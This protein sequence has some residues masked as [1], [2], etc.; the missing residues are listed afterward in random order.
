MRKILGF[1]FV[2]LLLSACQ[3]SDKIKVGVSAPLTG[4]IA[5]YGKEMMRGIEL[6]ANETGHPLEL[7]VEDDQCD[8]K[9]G[10]TV[11]QKL[12]ELDQVDAILGPVCTIAILSSAPYIEE[13]KVPE[14]TAGMVV[15]KVANA[16]DYHFSFLPEMK[17]QMQAISNYAKD[18]NEL[19]IAVLAINDDLGRESIQELKKSLSEQ[20]IQ[21]VAEEYL[22]K[23]ESDFKTSLLKLLDQKPDAVYL[24]GYPV[25]FV[26]I[27]RQASELNWKVSFLTWNLFQDPSVVKGLGSLAEQVVYTYPE[28][29]RDLPVKVAFKKKFKKVYGSEPTLYAANAYDSYKILAAAIQQCGKD[30]ECIKNK[31]YAIKN[32]EGA[33]GFLSV[34]ERGVG[35]RSEVSLK[36]VKNGTFVAMN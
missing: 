11:A 21:V 24:M 36:T 14:I 8:A 26:S 12:V 27:I 10:V 31:L 23:S 7:I 18:H 30:K 15:Q 35:Q 34:D 13:K 16:G 6:A 33:N 28:D 9:V 29:P 20:G 19:K 5:D 2:V 32:Y 22:D 25:H 1:L 3:S 4:L 17:Y